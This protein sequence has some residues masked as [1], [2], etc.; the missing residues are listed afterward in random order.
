MKNM[1][2]VD[3]EDWYH[4]RISQKYAN[5]IKGIHPREH[6]CESVTI[7]LDLFSAYEAR[8]TFF[9]LGDIAEKYPQLISDIEKKGHRIGAHGYSHTSVCLKSPEVFEA[10]L[11]RVTGLLNSLWSRPVES[12]R[13]PNWSIDG[14]CLWALDILRKHGYKYDSSLIWVDASLSQKIPAGII[15][16]PRST[17]QFG[18]FDIPLGG[19]FFKIYPLM[20][21]RYLMHKL[22]KE[23]RSFMMYVHPWE[24]DAQTP[25][26]RMSLRDSMIQNYATGY[27]ARRKL[28]AVLNN[29]QFIPMEDYYAEDENIRQYKD[30]SNF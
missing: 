16:I 28:E 5:Q 9:I 6:I 27:R 11:I 21:T 23:G 15:E 25:L 20:I 4:T 18:R 13:A 14:R 10:E 12:F 7:L 24:M 19:A 26:M 3:C 29:F 8:A 22:N 17:I 1:L 2:T 30:T